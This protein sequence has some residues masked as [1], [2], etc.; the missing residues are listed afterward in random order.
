MTQEFGRR[1]RR[2]MEGWVYVPGELTGGAVLA[3]QE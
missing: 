1:A 3:I 2:L